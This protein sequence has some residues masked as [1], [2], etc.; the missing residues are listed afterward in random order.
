MKPNMRQ[1]WGNQVSASEL[2]L[3]RSR[4]LAI[5]ANDLDFISLREIYQDRAEGSDDCEETLILEVEPQ[6][7]QKTVHDIRFKEHIAVV[8]RD[9]IRVPEVYALRSDF[10]KV[11]HTNLKEYDTPKSLCVYENQDE[12]KL[13]FAPGRFLED[14]RLW[15]SRTASGALHQEDQPLEPFALTSNPRLIIPR[16]VIQQASATGYIDVNIRKIED[17]SGPKALVCRSLAAVTLQRGES[18]FRLVDV[19]VPPQTHGLLSR[20][21]H[22]FITLRNLFKPAG[23]D[24]LD[25]VRRSLAGFRDLDKSKRPNSLALLLQLPRRRTDDAA[26]ENLEIWAFWLRPDVEQLGCELGIWHK[27]DGQLGALLKLDETKSG[28]EIEILSLNTCLAFDRIIA[29]STSGTERV[30]LKKIA[31]VGCGALGSQLFMNMARMGIGDWRLIDDDIVLP[32]NLARHA[33]IPGSEGVNKAQS[34]AVITEGLLPEG[35]VIAV[36]GRV[37]VDGV[38]SEEVL[39]ALRWADLIIDASTSVATSRLLSTDE[40]ITARRIAAFLNPTGTDA[41]LLAEDAH[42]TVTLDMLE[43]QYYGLILNDP[44]LEKHLD[45][46]RGALRY[47]TSCR[48]FSFVLP[49]SQVSTFAGILAGAIAESIVNDTAVIDVWRLNT[50]TWSVSNVHAPVEKTHS[51]TVGG[52]GIRLDNGLLSRISSLRNDRLPNE[53]GGVLL[54]SFDVLRRIIYIAGTI[55][56]PPD[57]EERVTSYIRGK[58]GLMEALEQ[59]RAAT[60]GQL[61]YVGEWH[62]HPRGA[63]ADPSDLDYD[64]L[65]WIGDVM[66]QYG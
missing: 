20:E 30:P 55:P 49:E 17:E 7:P 53:T 11:P 13:R 31:L 61:E 36:P 22:N 46:P 8:V 6:I 14:V 63:T 21:P 64:V 62:S 40:R 23:I 15:F 56:S 18:I 43:M 59:S 26:S 38:L 65:S 12:E 42:R 54:G 52:W 29:Q 32:H 34:L 58:K 41:V 16:T 24:L 1:T 25:V 51:T 60:Q 33:S 50:T 4:A 66:Q 5:A 9:E 2:R 10:P 44:L 37:Q 45:K 39:Q 19:V 47:S 48:D 57:S 3:S 35:E 27:Q 28:D